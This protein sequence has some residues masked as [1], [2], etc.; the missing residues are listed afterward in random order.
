MIFTSALLSAIAFASPVDIKSVTASAIVGGKPVNPPFKYPWLVSLENG[1]FHFCGGSLLDATTV[2]TA[3]HCSQRSVS[4]RLKVLAH[5]HDLRA[6]ASAEKGL[7]FKVTKITVH[8]KYDDNNQ[9]NDVAIWKVKLVSGDANL[10]NAN[11]IELDD[12]SFA[13]DNS[14]LV[15][16][17]WGT[18]SA[19]GSASKILL[20][21][22]VDVFNQ[23]S[24]KAQY[25]DLDATSICAA[26]PGKDTCQGDSGGP[27]FSVGDD[28]KVHL[29][30]LTSYGQG[31]ADP[32]YA[33]VYS[34]VSELSSWIKSTSAL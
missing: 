11:L 33:G 1:D 22:Q 14:T 8:P 9:A 18:T 34:R 30:G 7:E 23:E 31:C 5:R 6:S 17:G 2:V 20:E 19:G 29:V 13:K 27:M 4:S 15:V 16:S 32:K 10:I 12:G 28:G 24:C 21:T 25:P 26:A 3:A